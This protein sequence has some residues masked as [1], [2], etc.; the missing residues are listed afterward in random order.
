MKSHKAWMSKFQ[1][2][3]ESKHSGTRVAG[4]F[5][6]RQIMSVRLEKQFI[7]KLHERLV[8][9]KRQFYPS[10]VELEEIV[11]P[12]EQLEEI[13]LTMFWASMKF[14]EGRPL[15][16]RVTY[17]EPCPIEH[18]ALIF[19]FPP[20]Q[21]NVEEIRRLA[22][23]VPPPDGHLGVWPYK[24]F[25]LVIWGLLTTGST[26]IT[27]EILDPGRMVISFPLSSRVAEISGERSGFIKSDWNKAVLGLMDVRDVRDEH[28]IVNDILGLLYGKVTQ[29]ILS[30]IRTLR[31]GGTIIFVAD[32]DQWKRSLEK[33][34]TYDC[35]RRFNGIRHVEDGL[36][37]ELQD[38]ANAKL[39]TDD[40]DA[41]LSKGVKLLSSPQ[42][43][44][45]IAD[46]TRN[47]AYLTAV[48]GA[49]ILS[50]NFDVLTF[51][52]K[53]NIAQKRRKSEMVTSVLPLESDVDSDSS[54]IYEFRG[55]RHL[56]AARFILNNPTAVAFVV[57][58]DGGITAL[59]VNS[60]YENTVEKKLLAYKGLELLI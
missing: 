42:Y 14:E 17:T 28:H 36:R 23:A 19:G 44:A 1:F 48:D 30:Q 2:L 8:E 31:H 22:P 33:P 53:I 45:F 34:I 15:R 12:P 56:S 11:P 54:L 41:I 9:L 29:A 26:G 57:S 25:G 50:R 49:T 7:N 60:G 55:K 52:A 27:F 32:D 51:G 5:S 46:A 10:S 21:W 58:Q 20:R 6:E 18:L 24:Y 3:I 16:F 38:V 59:T 35:M 13:I 47:V 4:G 39:G 43:N 40:R 37:R